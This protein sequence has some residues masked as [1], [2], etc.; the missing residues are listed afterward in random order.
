M[1]APT[2]V[3]VDAV[4]AAGYTDVHFYDFN[5]LGLTLTGCNSAFPHPHVDQMAVMADGILPLIEQV[6]GWG[7]DEDG[8]GVVDRRD[9]CPGTAVGP[10][11]SVNNV[12]CTLA[13]VDADGDGVCDVPALSDG[14]DCSGTDNCPGVANADQSDFDADSLGDACDD[15]V[16]GDG[17]ANAV[18][19]CPNTPVGAT[20]AAAPGCST[21]QVAAF[22]SDGDGACDDAAAAAA[23]PSGVCAGV[24]P[25]PQDALDDSDGDGI[26]DSVDDCPSG[27]RARVAMCVCVCVLCVCVFCVCV[28]VYVC[29]CACVCTCACGC[30]LCV[31]VFLT[32]ALA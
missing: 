6:G 25:C 21:A 14:N 15:D 7:L 28:C 18:D 32:L 26:C 31:C 27:E 13:D 1:C 20:M 12:G 8:D 22:D 23:A 5:S 11:V 24:D 3:A 4:S 29:V 2:Q 30:A 16:D 10:G 17:A 19:A 9:A